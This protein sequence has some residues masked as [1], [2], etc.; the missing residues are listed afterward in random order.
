MKQQTRSAVPLWYW[1]I[2]TVA[3]LWNLLGC[4]FFAME[5]FAQEAMMHNMEYPFRDEHTWQHR[6]F[7]ANLQSIG[8]R[9]ERRADAPNHLAFSI[10]LMLSDFLIN[11]SLKLDRHLYQFKRQQESGGNAG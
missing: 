6:R 1:V 2:A 9:I 11:H 3:L 10:K 4:V 5:L 8:L 7:L